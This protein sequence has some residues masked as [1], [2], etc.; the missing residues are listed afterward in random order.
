ME[1]GL[2]E[3]HLS[4]T[5]R[6][7][8][9]SQPPRADPPPPASRLLCGPSPPP[10]PCVPTGPH[11]PAAPVSLI[12]PLAVPTVLGEGGY[13][14]CKRLDPIHFSLMILGDTAA[15]PAARRT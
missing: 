15:H 3:R 2:Q 8:L 5:A 7:P 6:L 14:F 13:G 11:L 4:E 1:V 9:A 10:R 12:G